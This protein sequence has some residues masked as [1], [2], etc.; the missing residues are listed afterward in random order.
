L[1]VTCE[2]AFGSQVTVNLMSRRLAV[3]GAAAAGV[4][5]FYALWHSHTPDLRRLYA[6][7]ME[8]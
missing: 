7:G 4:L 3:L 6:S 2:V 8:P 5:A 1:R